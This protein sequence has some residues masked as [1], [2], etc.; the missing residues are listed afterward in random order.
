MPLRSIQIVLMDNT[1]IKLFRSI[2]D[3]R[4][5]TDP[6]MVALWVEILIQANR[7]EHKYKEDMFEVGSFPTSL[8]ELSRNTGLT[9][10]QVRTG[11]RRLNGE[12]ITC[13]STNKGTKICVVKYAEFQGC[14]D[15]NNTQI[16]TQSTRNQHTANNSIRKKE[17]KKGRNIYND[18]SLPVYDASNN[19]TISMEEELELLGLMGRA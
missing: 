5:K 1:Y 6:N 10:Q 14:D 16:N 2:K 18:D 9:I 13:E 19:E 7:F 4:Y 3:W 8:Q 17:S 12:E 11:L 15:D